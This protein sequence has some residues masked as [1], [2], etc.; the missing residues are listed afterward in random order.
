[1]ER[2]LPPT[3]RPLPPTTRPHP[4]AARRLPGHRI[5]LR[6]TL[7]LLYLTA[8]VTGLALGH[9][10]GVTAVSPAAASRTGTARAGRHA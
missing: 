10:G 2:P 5:L 6:R 4:P 9:G 3:T 8:A 1:M 7:T